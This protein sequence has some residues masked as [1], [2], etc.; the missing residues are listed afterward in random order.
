MILPKEDDPLMLG[1]GLVSVYEENIYL[2][3]LR[4][5]GCCK[6][7]AENGPEKRLIVNGKMSCFF[8]I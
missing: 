2:L 1:A 5:Q 6:V 8:L 3:L 4:F 7:T